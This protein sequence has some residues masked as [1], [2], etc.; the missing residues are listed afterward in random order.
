ML[1]R[2]GTRRQGAAT[3]ELAVLTPLL[4]F[5]FLIAVDFARVFYQAVV[6]ADC[7]RCG[8]VYGSQDPEKSVDTA[9]IESAALADAT[10]LSPVPSV[11]STTGTDGDGHPFVEVT[12]QREFRTFVDY[13]GIPSSLTVTRTARM[14]VA[15]LVPKNS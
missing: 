3:V 11:A 8:A 15:P 2:P 5:L 6:L 12:V 7:A 13:P 10:D 1:L 9:G 14:R 4:M